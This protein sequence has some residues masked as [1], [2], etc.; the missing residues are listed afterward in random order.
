MNVAV[1]PDAELL[2]YRL[3]KPVA[4]KAVIGLAAI[5]D[6]AG[7]FVASSMHRFPL[8]RSCK[9]ALRLRSL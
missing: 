8:R 3:F 9:R 2:P 6:M 4:D 1:T 7:R 5:D